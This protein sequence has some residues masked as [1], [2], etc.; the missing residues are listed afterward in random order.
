MRENKRVTRYYHANTTTRESSIIGSIKS[1][2][3]RLIILTAILKHN[4]CTFR[5]IVEWTGRA[6]ST[7]LWHIQRLERE[8]IIVVQKR[9][10]GQYKRKHV[11]YTLKDTEYTAYIL[12][13]FKSLSH[14]YTKNDNIECLHPQLFQWN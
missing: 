5:Q 13:K 4:I 11:L 10:G 3:S 2:N 1:C 12:S 14:T 6:P 7:V 9:C 8:K